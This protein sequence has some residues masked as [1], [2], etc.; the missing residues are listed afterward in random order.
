M[1]MQPVR[2]AL[3]LFCF[4][5]IV[6]LGVSIAAAAGPDVSAKVKSGKIELNSATAQELAILP[7]IGMKKAEA[8]VEY[9]KT[10]GPFASAEDLLQVRGVGEKLL[11]KIKPMITVKI[12]GSDL[13]KSSRSFLTG[14]GSPPIPIFSARLRGHGASQACLAP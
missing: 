2:I 12:K 5:A 4:I 13:P 9:R 11:E 14:M 8:I 1:K 7:G 10:N 6:G 3:V